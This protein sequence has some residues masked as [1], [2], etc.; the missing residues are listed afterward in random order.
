VEKMIQNT[1]A[2]HTKVEKCTNVFGA[3]K[4][5]I[6]HGGWVIYDKM[7]HCT[8]E[9]IKKLPKAVQ[10]QVQG[11]YN[12]AIIEPDPLYLEKKAR[13]EQKLEQMRTALAARNGGVNTC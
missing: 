8:Q 2:Y 11:E 7:T 9:L 3:I 13:I 5:A 4:Y 10:R 6:E 1:H 12:N